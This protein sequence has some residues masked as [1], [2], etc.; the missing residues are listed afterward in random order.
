[1]ISAL[2]DPHRRAALAEKARR[3][4]DLHRPGDPLVLVNVWDAAAARVVA[5]QPGV[6]AIATGSWS[7]AAA[8]GVADGEQLPL[9]DA[10]A[11]I[12][13]VA[14]AVP[15]PVTADLEKGYGEAPEDVART[16]G[17]LLA[18]GAVG[19]NLED[20]LGDD[21]GPLRPVEEQVRRLQA[22][23]AA[24]EAVG[25]PLVLNARTDVL[26]GGGD[27][28]EA[29]AR[30]RAYLEAGADCVFVLG[31]A[32]LPTVRRLSEEFEGRL[33]VLAHPAMPSLAELAGAGAARISFGPGPMGAAYAELGRVAG[34]LTGRGAYPDSLRFRPGA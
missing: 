14:A 3:L 10:I 8:H 15:L 7:I 21:E 2:N 13:R 16:V 1:M 30:G 5:A 33:S 27:V 11:A 22:V 18:A 24:A 34:Q 26:A 9:A 6:A 4:R 29:A 19:C 28:D 20:S 23:R 31:V 12:G 25:V 32:D 17:L